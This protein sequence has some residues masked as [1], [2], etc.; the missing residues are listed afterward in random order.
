ME[1]PKKRIHPS[2]S[3]KRQLAAHKALKQA[4]AD[5]K[6]MKLPFCLPSRPHTGIIDD[7]DFS[8][9]AGATEPASATPMVLFLMT[10][11][12]TMYVSS[13]AYYK[14]YESVQR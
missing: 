8:A 10:A 6:Q 2:G 4:A 1:P 9:T 12:A 14:S 7:G 5:Q 3:S 11:T 13:Y